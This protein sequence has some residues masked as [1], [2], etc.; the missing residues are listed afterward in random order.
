[1]STSIL[2]RN[3]VT[4]TGSGGKFMLFAHGFGCDQNMWRFVAPAFEDD[5]RVV[6]L[7]YV[8]SGNSDASQYNHER[9]SSL[10]GYAQDITEI[11]EALEIKDAVFVGHSVSCMIGLLASIDQPDLFSSLIFVGPSPRYLND[12]NYTGGFSREDLDGLFE[13]MENNYLG[14]ASFLAPKIVQN[15]DRP[16][17]AAELEQSFCSIDPVISR[18]FAQVTFY[19]DNRDDLAKI[20]KPTLLLQ[21]ADD[22]IAPDSVGEYLHRQIPG[23]VLVKMKA[24]GHCPHL[25]HPEETISLIKQFLKTQTD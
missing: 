16:E 11:C 1:M 18:K 4:V 13:V 19:S 3:N 21:C 14:W 12:E 15:G 17:L 22:V 23:S 8:G 10:D 2:K 9:Y 6:R 25:S 7:D 24:T 5:Y 20:N